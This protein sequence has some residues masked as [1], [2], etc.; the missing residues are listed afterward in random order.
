MESGKKRRISYV[1][2]AV[3]AAIVLLLAILL[4]QQPIQ[5]KTT[6]PPSKMAP[7]VATAAATGV[8]GTAATLNGNL[9]A[10]GSAS[11]VTVGF[12]YGSD[13]GL[14]GA[15]NTTGVHEGA[16]AAFAAPV[17]GLTAG[18]A[19]YVRAWALGDGFSTGSVVSFTTLAPQAPTKAAPSVSTKAAT[20]TGTTDATLNGDLANL[21]TAASATVGFRYGTSATLTRATNVTVGAMAAIGG[22]DEPVLGLTENT[23]YY[24]QAWGLGDG[25]A[26]GSILS[27][28]TASAPSGNGQH[29]PPGWAHARCPDVPDHAPAHGVRARCEHNE[30]WGEMKKDGQ[31]STIALPAVDTSRGAAAIPAIASGAHRSDRSHLS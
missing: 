5:N 7:S 30:T 19:Y 8:G 24:V 4:L 11:D 1:A 20:D 27:F 22:F 12:W 13:P 10:L 25:F 9:A 26:N 17:G 15:T 16:A 23:T 29:V 14:A 31:A 28:T 2:A 21:G 18:T 6:P 3:A